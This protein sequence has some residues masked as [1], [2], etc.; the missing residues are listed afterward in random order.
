MP[1]ASWAEFVYDGAAWYLAASGS[2]EASLTATAT[3]DPPSVVTTASTPVQTVTLTGAALGDIVAMSFSLDLQGLNLQGWVS[4]ANT[5]SYRFSNLT[6][7]PIDLA[8]GTV[9]ARIIK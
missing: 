7:G 2:F 3:Y 5:V 8:S 9:K 4:S 6:G 1:T